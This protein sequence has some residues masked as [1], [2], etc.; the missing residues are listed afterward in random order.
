MAEKTVLID[1]VNKVLG[2]LIEERRTSNRFSQNDVAARCGLS[3]TYLSDIERGLR[4]LSVT[5]LCK[6]AT[7]LNMT[8]SEL[9][10]QAE[11][12]VEEEQ[13]QISVPR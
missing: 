13:E 12:K 5:S 7:A 11:A 8:V 10:L 2:R 1:K 9:L 4:N 3:R 6:I